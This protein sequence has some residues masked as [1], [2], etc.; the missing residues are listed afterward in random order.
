MIAPG[1]GVAF[2]SAADGDLRADI[3]AR[4]R[5]GD[6]L[7]IGASWATVS[8]VHGS[9]VVVVDAPGTHGE[10][11]GLVTTTVGLA[12]AVFTADC[13]GVVVHGDGGVGVA[14]AGWRGLVGGVVEALLETMRREGI[15]PR[16]AA[17]G[18]AIGPCCYEVGPEVVAR[19]GG[20]EA[21]TRDGRRSVDLRGAVAARL[22]EGGVG[23]VE[24]VGPCT[25]DGPDT[26]SH[27]RRGDTARMATIGWRAA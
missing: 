14:H 1:P 23:E 13:A 8:Q 2:T 21:R 9:R 20:F 5:V 16:R 12:L 4:R 25:F 11:D 24:V 3:A 26:Y 19:F 27:R 7:G 18:P 17:I 15:Q 6:T 10:A 22:R